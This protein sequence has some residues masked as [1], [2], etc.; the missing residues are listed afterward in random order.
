[1]KCYFLLSLSGQHLPS[2]AGTLNRETVCKDASTTVSCS[3]ITD[4]IAVAD[5]KYGTKL[6]TTCGLGN[7]SAGCCEY[8]G[9]D[10]MISYSGRLQ[11]DQC[12]G[13]SVCTFGDGVS[14]GD[15]TACGVDN[16]PIINHYFTME[17]YCLL[18]KLHAS[19]IL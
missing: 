14:S 8:D 3:T 13:R 16:Y 1:M 9:A 11:Q 12:S 18:G 2:S 5:I 15:T 17:Y 10:C 7:T 4:S 6:T 19:L